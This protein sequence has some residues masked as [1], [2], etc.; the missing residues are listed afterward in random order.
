MSAGQAA[1]TTTADG[2]RPG[3][4]LD[5]DGARTG[6]HECEN[7]D[8]VRV[9]YLL[10]D[11]DDSTVQALCAACTMAMFVAVAIQLGEAQD[12]GVSDLPGGGA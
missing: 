6:P 1:P 7:A 11:L 5:S 2:H 4:L 8:G 10:V 3:Q 12:G 9:R